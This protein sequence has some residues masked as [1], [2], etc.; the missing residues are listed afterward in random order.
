MLKEMRIDKV[1]PGQT[2]IG[3][4]GERLTVSRVSNGMSLTV[5]HG[6]I[7]NGLEKSFWKANETQ[8]WVEK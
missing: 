5:L 6:R 3:H 2:I 8:V 4:F 7:G 1:K